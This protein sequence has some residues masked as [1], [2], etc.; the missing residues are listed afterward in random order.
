MA[1]EGEP[2]LHARALAIELGVGIARRGMG[3]VGA[4]L[5]AEVRLGV[6]PA[7]RR[8]LVAGRPGWSFAIVPAVDR[9]EALHRGP[10][11]DQRA[12]D[13]EVL[14]RQKPLHPRLRQQRRQEAR[15]DRPFEE[16]IAVL[17]KGGVIPHRLV[18]PQPDKPAEQEIEL[19]PLHQLALRAYRVEGLKQHGPQQHLRGDRGSPDPG[20]KRRE[21]ALHRPQRI[22]NEPPDGAQRMILP[23][24]LLHVDI[25]EQRPRSLVRSAHIVLPVGR[26]ESCHKTEGERLFQQPA[27]ATTPAN[28]CSG[29]A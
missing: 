8:R 20:V 16:T 13:A 5:A 21:F 1:E 10:R 22:I 9:L 19:H 12:V 24:P 7:R 27:N 28:C 23:H 2:G 11:L 14:A 6:A 26:S 18:R 4:R 15:G 17:G 25:A 3:G 29:A